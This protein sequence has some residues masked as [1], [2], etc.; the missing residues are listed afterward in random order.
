M[1]EAANPAPVARVYTRA[2]FKAAM[3]GKST[4][5]VRALL[6]EPFGTY[7]HGRKTAFTYRAVTINP[8]TGALDA[9]VQVLFKDQFA[10]AARYPGEEEDWWCG[11]R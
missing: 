11:L 3:G 10:M 4:D 8:A 2:E 6:G 9:E 1:P 7:Q 5:E